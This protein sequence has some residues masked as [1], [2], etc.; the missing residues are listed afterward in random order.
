MEM[1]LAVSQI[2]WLSVF[3]EIYVDKCYAWLVAVEQKHVLQHKE[4]QLVQDYTRQAGQP[5]LTFPAQ[6]DNLML[7]Q[8]LL[9]LEADLP[10]GEEYLR[11]GV[12]VLEVEGG[13]LRL[14][15]AT[16]GLTQDQ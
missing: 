3:Y 1:T 2:A 15:A 13:S 5:Y 4:K 16:S 8:P 6:A 12:R 14:E 9:S 7:R 10:R 11:A